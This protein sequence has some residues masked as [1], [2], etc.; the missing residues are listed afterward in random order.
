MSLRKKTVQSIVWASGSQVS[1]QIIAF[2]TT[3][4]MARQLSPSDYGLMGMAT[5]ITRFIRMFR[6]MG[7]SS[8]MIQRKHTSE[9]LFSSVFWLNVASGLAFMG[10]LCLGAPLI[11]GFYREPRLTFLLYALSPGFVISSLGMLQ[12][13]L[14]QRT[15][16]FDALAKIEIFST[17][18]GG[19][20]GVFMAVKGMG[21]WSLVFLNLTG[22]F[23]TTA[24][25]WGS[26]NWRPKCHFLWNDIKGIFSYSLNLTGFNIINYFG[27][28][29]DYLLIGR[30]LGAQDLGIYTLAY[31]LMLYPLRNITNVVARVMLPVLSRVQ[32]DNM[33]FRSIYLKVCTGIAFITFPMMMGM[34]G[35]AAPL[36]L[37]VVGEKWMGVVP[38]IKILA[39]VGMLQSVAATVG[40][41]YQAKGRTDWMFL[42][43]II[44]TVV[45]TVGFAVGI[46]WGIVGVAWSYFVSITVILGG[47]A[48][49]LAFRLIDLKLSDF[50]ITMLRPLFCSLIMLIFVVMVRNLVAWQFR[51]VFELLV[52]VFCGILSY[53]II[54][55][56]LNRNL[57]VEMI[58][59]LKSK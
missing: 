14:L 15:M 58:Q 31:Q 2:V 26:S 22:A 10:L 57:M 54:T 40:S 50:L 8:A 20:V 47:P 17:L 18:G 1:R 5:V 6:D 53:G 35:T 33:R 12:N 30:Y 38:V 32:D 59:M 37:S 34:W 25:L 23:L 55:I 7:T 43:G 16:K 11:S 39:P 46:F 9:E 21:V 36:I 4:V 29:A 52:L 56:K 3:I 41:I 42:W 45:V 24:C 13:A 51:P 48:F 27:R 28:N 49:I 44:S 19:I